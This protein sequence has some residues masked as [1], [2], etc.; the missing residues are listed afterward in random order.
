MK[1]SEGER[2]AFE[3]RAGELH[4]QIHEVAALMDYHT[5]FEIGWAPEEAIPILADAL[6]EAWQASRVSLV[7]EIAQKYREYHECDCGCGA[8]ER[9]Y[10]TASGHAMNCR[11][12]WIAE[13]ELEYGLTGQ[14]GAKS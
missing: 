2:T 8:P 7:E 11:T 10:N 6:Q 1:Q 14:G 5:R 4:D 13:L 3:K 12:Y 9:K